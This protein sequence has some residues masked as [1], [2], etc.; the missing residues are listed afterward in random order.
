[1]GGEAARVGLEAGGEAGDA[2]FEGGGGVGRWGGEAA[3]ERAGGEKAE[4]SPERGEAGHCGSGGLVGEVRGSL[5]GDGSRG[6][7]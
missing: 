5:R 2:R 7:W 3:D 1:M 4:G 6:R